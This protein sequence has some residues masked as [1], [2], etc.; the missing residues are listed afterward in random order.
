MKNN[1]PEMLELTVNPSD[2]VYPNGDRRKYQIKNFNDT[3]SQS[4]SKEMMSVP[5]PGMPYDKNILYGLKGSE[6]G[7][8]LNFLIYNDGTDRA[9]GTHEET[10]VTIE[11]QIYYIQ[12]VLFAPGFIV[13]WSLEKPN[14]DVLYNNLP[15][16]V[17]NT[18]IDT[19]DTASNKWKRARIDIETG[20]SG[21]PNFDN[22]FG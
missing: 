13:A 22:I 3:V 2:D 6:S 11:E 5:I 1:M 16:V 18:D 7:I 14:S 21:L 17:T 15:V 4:V 20:H 12:D 9:G 19:I 8:T 10:V